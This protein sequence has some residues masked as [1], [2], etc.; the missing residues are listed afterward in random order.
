MADAR[1][2]EAHQDFLVP[3]ALH[4]KGFNFQGAAFPAQDGR[5]NLVPFSA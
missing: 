1:G 2:D 3:R 5:L 4:L